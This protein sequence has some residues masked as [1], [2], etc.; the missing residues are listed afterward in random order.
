MYFSSVFKRDFIYISPFELD[1][2]I[3]GESNVCIP[4]LHQSKILRYKLRIS[5]LYFPLTQNMVRGFRK[6]GGKVFE[7][8]A[9]NIVFGRK[10]NREVFLIVFRLGIFVDLMGVLATPWIQNFIQ[11]LFSIL[12]CDIYTRAISNGTL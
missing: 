4:P 9:E 7:K 12:L 3:Y 1:F 6:N 11:I 2:Y 8:N 5:S 10:F